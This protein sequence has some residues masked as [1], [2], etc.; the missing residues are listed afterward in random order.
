[1]VL[2]TLAAEREAVL[3]ELVAA[4]AEL[5]GEVRGRARHA[6]VRQ[7]LAGRGAGERAIAARR[8]EPRVTAHVTGGTRNAARRQRGI[9]RRVRRERR[10]HARRLL[11]Q[12]RVAAEAA[13]RRAWIALE[14]LDELARD[15]R[16]HG[17]RV[18]ARRPVGE[19]RWVA[20][21]A[22]FRR[23]RRLERREARG[24]RPLRRQ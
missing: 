17:S 24:R 14:H 15:A 2:A 6:S 18:E 12:R 16:P 4:A 23:Q 13:Q 7:G 5:R 20:G 21:A 1:G 22:R 3:A 19:L 9:E 11:G 10:G 8:A